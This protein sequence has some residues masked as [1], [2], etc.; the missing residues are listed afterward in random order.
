MLAIPSL[1]RLRQEDYH[2]FKAILDYSVRLSWKKNSEKGILQTFKTSLLWFMQKL[3][4]AFRHFVKF[5]KVLGGGDIIW[6]SA[7][8]DL[9]FIPSFFF[10]VSTFTWA[11]GSGQGCFRKSPGDIFALAPAQSSS[12]SCSIILALKGCSFLSPCLRPLGTRT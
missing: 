6:I 8:E 5:W 12:G 7:R 9:K 2:K 3:P 4:S 10:R 11:E 1:W